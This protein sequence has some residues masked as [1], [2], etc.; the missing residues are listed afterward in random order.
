MSYT[1]AAKQL[2]L[3]IGLSLISTGTIAGGY[4]GSSGAY[5]SIA[6][7][8]AQAILSYADVYQDGQFRVRHKE[9][10]GATASTDPK[11]DTAF[12]YGSSDTQIESSAGAISWKRSVQRSD[13]YA[14]TGSANA[15]GF[16]ASFVKV[17]TGDGKYYIFKGYASTS[18][19]AGPG[20]TAASRTGIAKSAGGRY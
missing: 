4:S 13:A 11:G 8:E 7:Q 20:G 3:A 6:P 14:K 1:Y 17:R 19:T 5:S 18:A 12:G 9:T 15:N 2:T 10:A 16:S